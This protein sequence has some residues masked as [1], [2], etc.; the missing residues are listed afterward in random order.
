MIKINNVKDENNINSKYVLQR[1]KLTVCKHN[2]EKQ[3]E[4]VTI[5]YLKLF[6]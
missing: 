3:L 4:S 5:K 1:K 6:T 2:F